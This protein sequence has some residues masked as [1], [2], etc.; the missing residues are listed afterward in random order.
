MKA[1]KKA[2]AGLPADPVLALRAREI[3]QASEALLQ[4][5]KVA[6][7]VRL[8][9]ELVRIAPDLP[10]AHRLMGV[11]AM[12]TEANDIAIGS[13]RKAIALKPG[14]DGLHL[15]LGQALL[16]A[17]QPADAATVLRKGLTL[18]ANNGNL[19]RE[20]GQAQLLLGE[21]EAALKSFRRALKLLPDDRYAAHM[22]GA[23]SNSGAASDDYVAHLFDTYAGHFEEH[24][25]GTLHYRVPQALAD[26]LGRTGRKLGPAIDIGCGTGLVGATLAD[27][28]LPIDGI[29]IAPNMIEKTRGRGLYR[30]LATGDATKVLRT[31]PD[32][33]GPYALAIAADVFIYMGAVEELFAAL[34]QRLAPDGLFAFSVETSVADDLEIRASGRFAHS[35][36]YIEGLAETHGLSILDRADQDI[37]LENKRPI[38]GALYILGRQ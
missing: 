31:N 7:A 8:A 6:E 15:D 2:P 22:V 26:M 13:F 3:M 30:H 34:M 25:T 35:A 19:L 24:L 21:K 4:E 27:A 36:K 28:A 37:R 12:R 14:S 17:E 38:A 9:V 18:N 11:L 33:A 29:D 16:A 20:L 10:A 23:L 5:D 1:S 32:F